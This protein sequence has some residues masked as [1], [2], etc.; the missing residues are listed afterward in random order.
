MISDHTLKHLLSFREERDWQQFHT[1]KNLAVSISLEAAELLEI[2]QWVPDSD[3]SQVVA[4]QKERICNEMADIAIYLNYLAHDLGVDLD[5]CVQKK[6]LL[7]E[8]KYPVAKSKG[9]A[10]KYDRLP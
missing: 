6:L 7:N 8:E 5:D 2:V 3:M 10:T 1:F 9:N 4:K